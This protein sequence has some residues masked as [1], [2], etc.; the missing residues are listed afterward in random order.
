MT[1]ALVADTPHLSNA[2]FGAY[3]RLLV[4]AWRTRDCSLPD[5]DKFLARILGVTPARWKKKIKPVMLQFFTV[6][7]NKWTQKKQLKVREKVAKNV[8]QKSRAGKS[9]ALKR[10][11]TR[12]TAVPTT[13]TKTK[14]NAKA[15]APE[16]ENPWEVKLY[17]V[18][19]NKFAAKCNRAPKDVQQFLENLAAK[20][21]G[22]HQVLVEA[23]EELEDHP[24][25]RNP[26]G[27]LKTV[28]ENRAKEKTRIPH[29]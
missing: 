13:K 29:N 14:A 19:I 12:P 3:M 10:Q 26:V 17:S 16:E 9:S 24:D 20:I 1:D 27:W 25:I 18:S 23:I 2:E 21:H 5:D 22:D 11:K 28:V 7:N 6:E 15:L 8:A 4:F